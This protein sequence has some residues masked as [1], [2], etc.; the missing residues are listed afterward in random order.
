MRTSGRVS[1][2]AALYWTNVSR[3]WRGWRPSAVLRAT[4]PHPLPGH[5]PLL[6]DHRAGSGGMGGTRGRLGCGDVHRGPD[7][8]RCLRRRRRSLPRHHTQGQ[9]LPAHAASRPRLLPVASASRAARDRRRVAGANRRQTA[10]GKLGLRM[11]HDTDKLI[12][13]LSLVAFLMAERRPLTARDVKSNVEGY[14]EMSDEAFARRFYSDRAGADR[15][16]VP[17][18]LAARRVH[19]RGA[20]HAP[21]GALLPRPARSSTTTS[22]PR[23]RPPSTCSRTRSPMRSP[24]GSPCR[25]SSSG[26]PVSATP[27]RRPPNAS[28]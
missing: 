3:R 10:S 14:S 11:S 2:I 18:D 28:A 1:R 22:W 7:R 23:C 19:G 9:G 12:R 24:S 13:Q 20:L 17:L 21:L 15:S 27:R 5:P 25:T 4:R 6:P 26:A 16:R 8:G